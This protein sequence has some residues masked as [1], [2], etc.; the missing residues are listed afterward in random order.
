M[1]EPIPNKLS[2]ELIQRFVDGEVTEDQD[3]S[4][5]LH[6]RESEAARARV[7]EVE[8]IRHLLRA[9]AAAVPAAPAG[10]AAIVARRAFA[11]EARAGQELAHALPFVRRLS[12]LAVAAGLLLAVLW[13]LLQRVEDWA[14]RP[15]VGANQVLSGKGSS[16]PHEA[17]LRAPSGEPSNAAPTPAIPTSDR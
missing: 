16:S 4:I 13:L 15:E 14:A 3:R 17:F 7:L 10:F 5:R 9:S 12:F 2:E 1:H 11:A 8:R 6:L